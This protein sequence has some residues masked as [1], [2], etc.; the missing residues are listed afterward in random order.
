MWRKAR[1][2][3]V[4]A[5]HAVQV[6]LHCIEVFRGESFRASVLMVRGAFFWWWGCGAAGLVDLVGGWGG[7]SLVGSGWGVQ[8]GPVQVGLLCLADAFLRLVH[9]RCSQQLQSVQSSDEH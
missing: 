3:F 1:S 5:L 8:Q 4:F 6:D 9:L 7:V 2:S